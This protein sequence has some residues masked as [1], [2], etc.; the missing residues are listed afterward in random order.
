LCVVL[1]GAGGGGTSGT[2]GPSHAAVGLRGRCH[3]GLV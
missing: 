2:G 1:L 3:G